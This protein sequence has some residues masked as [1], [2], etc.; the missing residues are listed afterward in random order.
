MIGRASDKLVLLAGA[1]HS[2]C[3]PIITGVQVSCQ[4]SQ[5]PEGWWPK[6]RLAAIAKTNGTTDFERGGVFMKTRWWPPLNWNAAGLI[7]GGL[8]LLPG[9][10]W[11][12]GRFRNVMPP[13]TP[14]FPIGVNGNPLNTGDVGVTG[15]GGNTGFSGITAF[16]GN[17]GIGGGNLGGG[18][19]GFGIGNPGFGGGHL[20][21]GGGQ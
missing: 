17:T 12:E 1:R 2:T 9:P 14:I 7:V 4:G 13:K 16:S 10:T 19:Q 18:F 8:L 3:A 15:F 6:L 11:A 5:P 21:I 20:G